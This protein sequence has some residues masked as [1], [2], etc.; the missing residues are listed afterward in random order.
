MGGQSAVMKQPTQRITECREG[1]DSSGL[2][3][4]TEPDSMLG[5]EGRIGHFQLRFS[6]SRH[7]MVRWLESDVC[8]QPGL[9]LHWKA[10][11]S[12]GMTKTEFSDLCSPYW[13]GRTLRDRSMVWD[14]LRRT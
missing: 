7:V 2:L 8:L 11:C 1:K 9:E 13:E 4:G 12:V 6:L 5:R 10:S 14:D 3:C